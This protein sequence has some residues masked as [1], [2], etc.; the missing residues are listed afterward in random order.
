MKTLILTIGKREIEV[1]DFKQAS[2]VYSLARDK[3]GQGASKFPNGKL[4]DNKGNVIA[5]ISY[6][7][8]VWQGE[9]WKS[10]TEPL[11]NP[12]AD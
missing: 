1:V 12:Y 10:G 7:G 5:H 3:S 9:Q 6:N 11:Y 4:T 2:Y 8:K